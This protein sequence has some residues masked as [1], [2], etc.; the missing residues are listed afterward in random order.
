MKK[1]IRNILSGGLLGVAMAGMLTGCS[2]NYLNVA[3]ET[4]ISSE[5]AVATT[6]AA[7]LLVRGIAS[8][9][10]TQ[11]GGAGAQIYSG[12][13]YVNAQYNDGNGM[14]FLNGYVL[15][16]AEVANWDPWGNNRY[17]CVIIPW[18]YCYN[19]IMRSNA[20]LDGID[21]AE[22][23]EAERKFIKAQAL[24]FRA[25]AYIKLLQWYAPRWEDSNNGE[26]YCIVLRTKQNTEELPLSTMKEVKDQLY[27]DLNLAIQLYDESGLTR[28][29][30]W[31]TDKSVACGLYSRAALIFHDWDVAQ[32]MAAEAQKGYQV[33][34]NNTLFAGF[35]KDNDDFIWETGAENSDVYYWSFGSQF[36][37]NGVY[38]QAWQYGAGAISMALYNQLDPNDVRRKWFLTPDKIGT[39]QGVT[40]QGKVDNTS[41]FKAAFINSAK[42]I[43]DIASGAAYDRKKPAGTTGLVN[44]IAF[45]GKYYMENI[46]TG[47]LPEVMGVN[48][49]QGIYAAYFTQGSASDLQSYPVKFPLSTGTYA[50]VQTTP[51][52]AQYK[53]WS[54]APYGTSNYPIF[55]CAEMVL[56]EAEAAY[57]AGSET[58]AKACLEKINKLRI[59]GYTCTTSG[60]ALLDEIRLC[61][62]I[63]LWGEGQSWSDLKRW[64]LPCVRYAWKEGDLNSG[65]VSVGCSM[66]RQPHEQAGWRLSV[67]YSEIDFNK[68]IDESLLP[69]TAE[70]TK[71]QK[72]E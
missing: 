55:R 36:A 49:G 26:T 27:Y 53:F 29:Y 50:A 11:Y 72:P 2:E 8:A 54:Y 17:Y 65:N 59:P 40:N 69:S 34:D 23:P 68:A 48:T 57:M 15:R 45:Y 21:N 28:D 1:N 14:D 3:P 64:N 18:N 10:N 39:I 22:G 41:C 67:P 30:K 32:Q 51:L 70:Y 7:R 9:M 60:Q 52:G 46:F 33:M 5:S 38:P 6:K 19:I 56:N 20:V 37:C 4:D 44:Y 66:I 43:I 61:R 24:T 71:A 35:Y 58:V 63:E 25:H 47:S 13:G 16:S 62:R 31:E 12:E 42:G